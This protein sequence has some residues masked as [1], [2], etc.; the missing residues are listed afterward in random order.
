MERLQRTVIGDT[1][2]VGARLCA[3][4][5]AG[6]ILMSETL[7]EVLGP[8]VLTGVPRVIQIKGKAQPMTVYPVL[9]WASLQEQRH[10]SGSS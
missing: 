2:N 10:G 4:A 6:E 7:R 1:V 5:E 9:G 8:Q 3:V